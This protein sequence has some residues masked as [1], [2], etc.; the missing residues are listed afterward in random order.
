MDITL[1]ISV[2]WFWRVFIWLLIELDIPQ[3]SYDGIQ[4]G[5]ACFSSIYS[6]QSSSTYSLIPSS[7]DAIGLV[8]SLSFGDKAPSSTSFVVK[9]R[10]ELYSI[11]LDVED[12]W[13]ERLDTLGISQYSFNTFQSL[14]SL[15]I[16][17]DLFLG[18]SDYQLNKLP[19]L[20]SIQIGNNSFPKVLSFSLTGLID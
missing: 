12:L 8:N 13:I 10:T 19:L 17:N 11:P 9:N 15:V 16:G 14:K 20:Q 1:E 7:F 3:L 6:V 2:Q 18:I 5:L 4:F